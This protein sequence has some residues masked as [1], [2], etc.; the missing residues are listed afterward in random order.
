MRALILLLLSAA[1]ASA[2]DLP[3]T[4]I[5]SYTALTVLPS[6]AIPGTGKLLD[7]WTIYA[8]AEAMLA[9]LY[10]GNHFYIAGRALMTAFAKDPTEANADALAE[11]NQTLKNKLKTK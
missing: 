5:P 1:V 3:L 2:V 11:F 4:P 6:S 7:G 9:P 8:E 10:P